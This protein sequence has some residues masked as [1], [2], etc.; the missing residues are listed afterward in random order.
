MVGRGNR[1]KGDGGAEPHPVVS[2]E[3]TAFLRGTGRPRPQARPLQRSA[4]SPLGLPGGATEGSAGKGRG[5]DGEGLQDVDEAS[6]H[7]KGSF[8]SGRSRGVKKE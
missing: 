1:C 3:A 7:G 5:G 2:A 6:K 4:V 8:C